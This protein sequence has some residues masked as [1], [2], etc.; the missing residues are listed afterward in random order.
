M[1]FQ[2][3]VRHWSAGVG[4]FEVTPAP[5]IALRRILGTAQLVGV[6]ALVVGYGPE[7]ESPLPRDYADR[8]PTPNIHRGRWGVDTS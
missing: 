6:S 3:V 5:A 4:D 7:A 2:D 8:V 1:E